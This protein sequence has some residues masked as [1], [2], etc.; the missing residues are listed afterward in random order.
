MAITVA[1]GT[2]NDGATVST[3]TPSLTFTGTDTG[4]LALDYQLQISDGTFSIIDSNV[5][6]PYVYGTGGAATYRGSQSFTGNGSAMQSATFKFSAPSSVTGSIVCKL[7]SHQGVYGTSSQPNALIA[8][9]SN[10][11]DISILTASDIDFVFNFTPQTLTNGVKYVIAIEG[12]GMTGT[13]YIYHDNNSHSGNA[14]SG[15]ASYDIV[16]SGDMYFIINSDSILVNSF[17]IWHTGFSAGAS[18]PTTSGVEQTYVVQTNLTNATT[19]Y[20]RVRANAP[21]G[22]SVWGAWSSG[23]STLGYDSFLVGTPTVVA[24]ID[25]SLNLRVLNYL[26]EGAAGE[27]IDSTGI[28]SVD[29]LIEGSTFDFSSTGVLTVVSLIEGSI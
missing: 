5:T 3:L 2:P 4:S 26:V 1:L 22:G 12:S 27:D 28:F 6:F 25:S 9:S 16:A 8:T 11:L 21:G 23:D 15:V 20:W 13:T 19:Y 10:T 29:T 7:F 24:T 14:C 17:S 18:H